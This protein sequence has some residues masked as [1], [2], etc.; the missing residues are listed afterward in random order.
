MTT[1]PETGPEE[2]PEPETKGKPETTVVL[3]QVAVLWLH[4]LHWE[5]VASHTKFLSLVL[6]TSTFERVTPNSC[7]WY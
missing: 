5:M 4:R 1:G 7:P 2:I 3:Y 6:I